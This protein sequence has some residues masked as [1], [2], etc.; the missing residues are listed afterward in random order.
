LPVGEG[1]R[2]KRTAKDAK[3]REKALRA[4]EELAE[5][6][7][8]VDYQRQWRNPLAGAFFGF[9]RGSSS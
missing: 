1:C 6:K 9:V 2:K 3:T 7:A 8:A 4:N 5:W